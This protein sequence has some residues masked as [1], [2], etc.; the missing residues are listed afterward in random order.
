MIHPRM[1]KNVRRNR[2]AILSKKMAFFRRSGGVRMSRMMKRREQNPT[3]KPRTIA[4][5]TIPYWIELISEN[6]RVVG[7]PSRPV[8][9]KLWELT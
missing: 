9:L 8:T 6:D 4:S 3:A 7:V 5:V 1:E 2:L